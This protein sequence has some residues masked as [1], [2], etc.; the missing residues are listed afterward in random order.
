MKTY[1]KEEIKAY[2]D[3]LVKKYDGSP[4]AEQA[5]RMKMIMFDTI[6]WKS[7]T[8]EEVTKKLKNKK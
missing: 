5:D 7:D 6:Y 2:F 4:F 3:Y 1:T 8:L